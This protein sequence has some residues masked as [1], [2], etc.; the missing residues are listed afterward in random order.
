[1]T[2][3]IA[4]FAGIPAK[5]LIFQACSSVGHDISTKLSTKTLNDL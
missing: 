1:M 3:W 4:L 5:A 2:S